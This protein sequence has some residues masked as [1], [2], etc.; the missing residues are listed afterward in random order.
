MIGV[1][2]LAALA[3]AMLPLVYLTILNA[4][5]GQHDLQSKH[6]WHIALNVLANVLCLVFAFK[7]R[8]S[9]PNRLKSSMVGVFFAF[10]ILLLAILAARLYYSR[11]VLIASF[12]A[13]I[14]LV[15]VFALLK[16][17]YGV[18]RI[19]VVP[20]GI[21]GKTMCMLGPDAMLLASPNEPVWAYDV[22]VINWSNVQDR[23]WSQFATRAILSGCEV[24]H[25]AAYIEDQQGRVLAEHFEA[26]HAA[27]PRTSHY[28]T[29]Y[30]R[31]LDVLFVIAVA[32][33]ALFILGIASLAILITMGRPIFFTQMRM[34]VDGKPFRMYKLRTMIQSAPGA[35][36]VATSVGD[37]RVTPLG[38]FLRR[39]RIDEIPQFYNILIG[40]MSLIGPR[41][42]QPELARRYARNL[43]AFNNRT[44]LRPGIT[45]W[46][47]VR[48][49]YAADEHE[50]VNKLAYDLYYVKHAS[51][52]MDLSVVLQ[53][54]KT[55]LTGNSAR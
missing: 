50:T 8:G 14:A 5:L 12:F 7:A 34:G 45:G 54:F 47:Q 27:T 22:I 38:K 39:V 20:Q 16:E 4:T 24:Q 32:P 15:A 49:T 28:I 37:K 26:D 44:M 43:P 52:V 10:G 9:I 25:V 3:A 31:P 55:L 2:A 36:C 17:R 21:D 19:G 11:P 42:E 6:G 1:Y 18:R 40:N 46:A 35:A 33:L 53:T 30:K 41:P 48:G 23:R 13:S 29:T 51:F